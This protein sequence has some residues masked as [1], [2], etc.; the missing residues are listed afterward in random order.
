VYLF[1]Q[2]IQ[3]YDWTEFEKEATWFSKEYARHF[4]SVNVS[5]V[6]FKY[7]QQS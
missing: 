3:I 4:D 6:I 2:E 7:Q 5:A 1:K